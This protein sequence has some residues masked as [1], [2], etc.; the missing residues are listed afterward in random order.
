M[1]EQRR[2]VL[3]DQPSRQP[4]A[5]RILVRVQ[6]SLDTSDVKGDWDFL[7]GAKGPTC[8]NQFMRLIFYPS[9]AIM[10][11]CESLVGDQGRIK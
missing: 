8:V 2:D 6:H 5:C 9:D 4:S 10:C 7:V 1:W 11:V 3:H